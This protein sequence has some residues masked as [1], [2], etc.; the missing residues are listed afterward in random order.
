[1]CILQQNIHSLTKMQAP[2]IH[3]S[4]REDLREMQCSFD[5]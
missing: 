4:T 5:L 1:L 3:N 2:T